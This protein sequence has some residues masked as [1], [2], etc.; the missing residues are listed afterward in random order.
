M[1]YSNT[2]L[3]FSEVYNEFY[4]LTIRLNV[5][6]DCGGSSVPSFL[7]AS[8]LPACL[9]LWLL[10]STRMASKHRPLQAASGS[11]LPP[12]SSGSSCIILV[13]P[14]RSRLP[15]PVWDLQSPLLICLLH[16][17]G[18]TYALLGIKI[19]P[20]AWILLCW[21]DSQ[22]MQMGSKENV[23]STFIFTFFSYPNE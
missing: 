21:W 15:S 13:P 1:S 17:H 5:S 20:T 14:G 4:W 7:P 8:G 9:G 12:Y 16:P 18:T 6:T 23:F 3:L 10:L 19:L 2:A 22:S 11:D